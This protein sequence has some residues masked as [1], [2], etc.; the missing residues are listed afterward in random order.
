MVRKT[1]QEG[2]SPVELLGGEDAG[3]F[4]RQGHWA[5]APDKISFHKFTFRFRKT[6]RAADDDAQNLRRVI[7]K[8]ACFL[9]KLFGSDHF[10]TFM[11]ITDPYSGARG[12]WF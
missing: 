3:Q 7:E 4:V 6:V 8:E 12:S 9:S 11:K 5:K 10:R 1:P 2:P